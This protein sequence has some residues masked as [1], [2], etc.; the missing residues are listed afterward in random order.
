MSRQRYRGSPIPV[1]YET[2]DEK[3]LYYEHTDEEMKWRPEEQTLTRNVIQVLVKDK[4]SQMYA[5]L[6]RN[7]IND[8]TGFF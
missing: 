3:V 7:K 8:L 1:Y 5:W 4:H 6:N 2:P